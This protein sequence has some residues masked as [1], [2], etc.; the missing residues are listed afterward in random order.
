MK[1]LFIAAAAALTL[2]AGSASAQTAPDASAASAAKLS[3]DSQVTDLIA[4]QKSRAIL[5]KHVPIVVEYADMIPPGLSLKQ[6]GD[7]EEARSMA[8][9]TPEVL[10]AI[11]DELAAL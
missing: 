9:L 4:N 2:A 3:A 5:E 6:L 11:S 8:G 10:K 7:V 1:T